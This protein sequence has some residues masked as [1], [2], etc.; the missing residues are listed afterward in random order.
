MS[1]QLVKRNPVEGYKNVFP[2]TFIDA[3]K[4]RES[5]ASL[6]EIIQGFNMYFLSYLFF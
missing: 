6:E 2:K 5:G 3:I 1:N 4:D